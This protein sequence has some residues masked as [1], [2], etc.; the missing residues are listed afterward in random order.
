MLLWMGN[1][2]KD[3]PQLAVLNYFKSR[4]LLIS[5]ALA[6]PPL[7][8]SSQTPCAPLDPVCPTAPRPYTAL[9]VSVCFS[10]NAPY[11]TLADS[12]RLTGPGTY[13]ACGFLVVPH[14]RTGRRAPGTLC[15]YHH[16][17]LARAHVRVDAEISAA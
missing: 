13:T 15:L 1:A 6:A 9:D 8:P 4:I 16:M 14:R 12:V 17:E 11:T 7:N 2:D 5:A 3:C 10:G